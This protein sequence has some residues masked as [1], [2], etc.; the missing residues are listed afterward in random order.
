MSGPENYAG[1]LTPEEEAHLKTLATPAEIS[2]YMHELELEAGLRVA[3]P[4]NPSVIHIVERPAVQPITSAIT[5]DGKTYTFSGTQAEIDAAQA[6]V[7]RNT[8]QSSEPAKLTTTNDTV[9]RT[10]DG[11]FARQEQPNPS[12]HQGLDDVTNNL[13]TK[14]LAETGIDIDALKQV[15]LEKQAGRQEVSAWEQATREFVKAHPD[16]EGGEGM[17]DLFATKLQELGLTD[18]PSAKSLQKAYDALVADEKRTRPVNT[19]HRPS[20]TAGLADVKHPAI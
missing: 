5:I 18:Q 3:D 17:Q 10:A 2:S 8:F 13:V 9:A 12:I 6:N 19:D 11:R 1:K 14:A 4:M 16:W 20:L 7:F 15:V